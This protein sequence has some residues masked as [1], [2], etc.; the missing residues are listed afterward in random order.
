MKQFAVLVFAAGAFGAALQLCA[1]DPAGPP[2]VL[3][4]VAENIKEGKGAAHEKSEATFM[5]AAAKF[6]FPAH[7]LGLTSITGTSQ[8]WF[9]EA[10][11]NFAAIMDS[12]AAMN[13]PELSG[14]DAADADLRTGS[15]SLIAAFRPDLSYAVDK[16]QLVKSRF[17]TVVT[18]Q[19]RA[20]QS[21]A[22]DELAKFLIAGAEKS[23]DPT[24]VLTYQ[25]V[26]GAAD[27]TYLLLEPMESLRAMDEARQAEPALRQALGEEGMKR[28]AKMSADT[29]RSEESI[30]FSVNPR[31]SYV[32]KEWIAADPEFWGPKP[33]Q[34]PKAR[35]TGAK[36]T[37][38]K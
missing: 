1:Q 22:F 24:S 32:P 8:A 6:H 34:T 11:D 19:T 28:W 20:G 31:M 16:A 7:V 29:I 15:R 37:A 5:Q 21:P 10:Y 35:K 4:I 9:L 14:I 27:G 33:A 30:L 18:I 12:R 23:R 38:S 17:F 3:Q 26:S 2:P 13:K 36:T 25:V